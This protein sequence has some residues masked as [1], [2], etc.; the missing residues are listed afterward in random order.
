MGNV[1]LGLSVPLR[2]AQHQG[3]FRFFKA[4]DHVG[5][6]EAKMALVWAMRDFLVWSHHWLLGHWMQPKNTSFPQVSVQ[7]QGTSLLLRALLEK[8]NNVTASSTRR[9]GERSHGSFG[10]KGQTRPLLEH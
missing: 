3:F 8:R 1:F 4:T 9:L 6:A 5:G 7:T 10:N 2:Q